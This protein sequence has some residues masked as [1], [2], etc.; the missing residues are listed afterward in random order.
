M[1]V[2]SENT[3]DNEEKSNYISLEISSLALST[4]YFAR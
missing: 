1:V 4:E 3:A 2:D